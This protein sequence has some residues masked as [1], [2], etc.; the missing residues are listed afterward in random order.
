M[1]MHGYDIIGIWTNGL[2]GL[3]GKGIEVFLLQWPVLF[4]KSKRLNPIDLHSHLAI[5]I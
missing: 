1:T 2:F 4:F 5:Y 3:I